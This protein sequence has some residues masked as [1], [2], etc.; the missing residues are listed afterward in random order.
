MHKCFGSFS[1]F[2]NMGKVGLSDGFGDKELDFYSSLLDFPMEGLEG[3]EIEEWDV[4]KFQCLDPIPSDF[5]DLSILPQDQNKPPFL[6]FAPLIES[7]KPKPLP[8]QFADASESY[9]LKQK[10]PGGA[11]KP[12]VFQS[13]SPVSV[14]SRLHDT[15]QIR[16]G[17]RSK[18]SKP[19]A[20]NPWFGI[21]PVVS[22]KTCNTKNLSSKKA[23]DSYQELMDSDR[24]SEYPDRV[25]MCTHCQSTKTPQWREGPMGPQTL[26]N[27]CGVRFRTGRLFP[28]YRP[29]NSPTF[30]PSLHSNS[31]KKVLEMRNRGKPK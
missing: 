7:S 1:C 3:D 4:S 16:R 29:A 11:Q 10:N 26:C 12:K 31:H 27:A 5:L 17:T 9:I 30:V 14:L 28:E 20:Q 24:P 8:D 19:S 21:S 18:R 15:S 6:P 2:V 13:Q 22:K 23:K 25:K